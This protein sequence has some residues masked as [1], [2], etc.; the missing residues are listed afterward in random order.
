MHEKQGVIKPGLTPPEQ[1]KPVNKTASTKNLEDH[2]TT[3]LTDK[4]SKPNPRNPFC[5]GC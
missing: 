4:A 5:G 3:R 1:P 2:T